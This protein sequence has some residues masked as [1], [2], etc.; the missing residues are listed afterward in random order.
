MLELRNISFEEVAGDMVIRD[1]Y[2][3]PNLMPACNCTFGVT[4]LRDVLTISLGH[5]P[6]AV[7]ENKARE[8]I[9]A[10]YDSLTMSLEEDA[11][12]AS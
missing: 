1:A 9:N 11:S 12:V 3:I 7:S 5:K 4:S 8:I 10:V 2:F 6:N